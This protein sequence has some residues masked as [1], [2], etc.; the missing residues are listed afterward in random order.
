MKAERKLKEMMNSFSFREK[1]QLG[2]EYTGEE[3]DEFLPLKWP[4]TRF[5]YNQNFF[6]LNKMKTKIQKH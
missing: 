2:G 4:S 1:K 5:F 6:L 3:R